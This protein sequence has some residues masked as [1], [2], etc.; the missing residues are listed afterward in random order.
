[1][2]LFN[3]LFLSMSYKA[4]SLFACGDF[5]NGTSYLLVDP[6]VECWTGEHLVLLPF[7]ILAIF[8]Y[9]LGWP[10]FLGLVFYVAEAS[11]A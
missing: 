4:L 9:T 11:D 3:L 8:L 2:F 5:K 1:M 7:G 6:D 10:F